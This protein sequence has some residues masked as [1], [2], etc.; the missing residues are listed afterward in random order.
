MM[1][2]LKVVFGGSNGTIGIR[3]DLREEVH[4]LRGNLSEEVHSVRG[5]LSRRL[6]LF[7]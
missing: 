5:Y 4:S 7:C 6:T 3:G 1:L 2:L